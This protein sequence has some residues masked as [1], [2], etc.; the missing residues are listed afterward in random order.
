MN[1]CMSWSIFGY[2]K[3]LFGKFCG[4]L[5]EFGKFFFEFSE[6]SRKTL[7]WYNFYIIFK[8]QQD[9]LKIGGEKSETIFHKNESLWH[10]PTSPW[11]Q[12]TTA[13]V[14]ICTLTIAYIWCCKVMINF[15]YHQHKFYTINVLVLTVDH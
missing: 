13:C 15:W 7:F 5:G 4:K 8:T 2:L 10:L 1:T 6:K 3:M 9:W 12:S 11:T 14:S